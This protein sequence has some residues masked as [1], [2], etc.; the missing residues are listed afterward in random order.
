MSAVVDSA[1]VRYTYA[2]IIARGNS[3]EI[4]D[5]LTFFIDAKTGH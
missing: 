3:V 1:F 4:M 5:F 2:H